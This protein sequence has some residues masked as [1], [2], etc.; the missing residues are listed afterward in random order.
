MPGFLVLGG[1]HQR[2]HFQHG[3]GLLTFLSPVSLLL[4]G[5][6]PLNFSPNFF[7][8]LLTPLSRGIFC[9]LCCSALG[10]RPRGRLEEALSHKLAISDVP[11]LILGCVS[12]SRLAHRR[13][14][15]SIESSFYLL[16]KTTEGGKKNPLLSFLSYFPRTETPWV[17]N[18]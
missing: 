10:S 2:A 18:S 16:F 4:F 6:T 13:L 1:W 15:L 9:S 3:D 7:K 11:A 17:V 14:F 8:F 12:W 5:S